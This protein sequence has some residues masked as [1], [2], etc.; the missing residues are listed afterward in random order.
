E[1]PPRG[2][3]S[4]DGGCRN[5][6]TPIFEKDRDADTSRSSRENTCAP[7]GFEPATLGLEAARSPLLSGFPLPGSS[8]AERC[9][10][11]P[12]QRQLVADESRNLVGG[13][14]TAVHTGTWCVYRP[15]NTPAPE[16][17]TCPPPPTLR[18]T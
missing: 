8:C 13:L 2:I 17:D 15:G 9:R 5:G 7:A 11:L 1:T 10:R 6:C 4:A 3:C 16:V 12:G 18:R 14:N